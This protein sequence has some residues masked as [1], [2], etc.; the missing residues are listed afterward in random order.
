MTADAG[1]RARWS[2]ARRRR[3]R[4]PAAD[5]ARAGKTLAFVLTFYSG[6]WYFS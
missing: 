5:G 6:Q 2:D 4:L 1:T 3:L